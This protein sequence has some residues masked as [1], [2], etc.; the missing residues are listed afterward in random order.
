MDIFVLSREDHCRCT[1]DSCPSVIADRRIASL[2]PHEAVAA[3]AEEGPTT[4][5]VNRVAKATEVDPAYRRAGV[6]K[7]FVQKILEGQSTRDRPHWDWPIYGIGTVI[8]GIREKKE[9]QDDEILQY[10][11]ASYPAI[12]DVISRSFMRFIPWNLYGLSRRCLVAWMICA[13][14]AAK[15]PEMKWKMYDEKTLTLVKFCWADTSPD[16]LLRVYPAKLLMYMTEESTDGKPN[17]P[18]RLEKFA[19]V[20]GSMPAFTSSLAF[21]LKGKKLTELMLWHEIAVVRSLISEWHPFAKPFLEGDIPKLVMAAIRRFMKTHP[22]EEFGGLLEEG[23]LLAVQFILACPPSDTMKNFIYLLNDTCL[24]EVAVEGL[25][26]A[27]IQS[28]PGSLLPKGSGTFCLIFSTIS[29]AL[30]VTGSRCECGC[31]FRS[32]PEF[33]EAARAAIERVGL[34]KLLSLSLVINNWQYFMESL[35]ALS[36]VLGVSGTSVRERHRLDRKCCNVACPARTSG[37]R[38]EKKSACQKCQSVYYCDRECQ[39]KDW[40]KHKS[41]CATFAQERESKESE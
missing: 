27:S 5:F 32:S 9:P 14:V 8:H 23:E 38:S 6:A 18:D 10:L 34:Q 22:D 15:D 24:I 7:I 30:S 17:P 2:K 11:F 36:N 13:Y 3:L 40:S 4:P 33:T 1:L 28:P 35:G 41:E 19:K 16:F 20:L 29:H 37:K 39:K 12:I 21:I 26:L 25:K 31:N